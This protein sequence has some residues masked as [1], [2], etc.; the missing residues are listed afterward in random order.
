MTTPGNLIARLK[1]SQRT[2]SVSEG[3]EPRYWAPHSKKGNLRGLGLTA[4]RPD[5]RS[6][7]GPRSSARDRLN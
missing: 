3:N 2:V 1:I 6:L 4:I 7:S 5:N